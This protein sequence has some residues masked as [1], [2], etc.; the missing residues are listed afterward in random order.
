[1][2]F[3]LHSLS[4]NKYLIFK[5]VFLFCIGH[6]LFQIFQICLNSYKLLSVKQKQGIV[7]C[8]VIVPILVQ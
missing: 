2:S 4:I 5:Y 6:N 3:R 8:P 7:P 1:M